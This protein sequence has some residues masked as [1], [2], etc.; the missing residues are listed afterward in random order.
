MDTF[1]SQH[2]TGHWFIIECLTAHAGDYALNTVHKDAIEPIF[3][4]TIHAPCIVP[5]VVVIMYNDLSR[6]VGW[7]NLGRTDKKVIKYI[8]DVCFTYGVSHRM[9]GLD[10]WKISWHFSKLK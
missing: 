6:A 3:I 5:I 2:T 7:G 9:I 1:T 10:G 8:S 4:D